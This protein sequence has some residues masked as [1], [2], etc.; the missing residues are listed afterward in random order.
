MV[1]VAING[2]PIIGVIH[3]PFQDGGTAWAWAG[4]QFKSR[5]V[6]HSSTQQEMV[7]K[8]ARTPLKVI[9]GG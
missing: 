3:K 1:C 8:G 6:I 5:S 9:S 2:K 7:L 4:T